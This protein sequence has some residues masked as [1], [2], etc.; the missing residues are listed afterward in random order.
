MVELVLN[1]PLGR[2]VAGRIAAPE[3]SLHAPHLLSVEVASA[4]R[5]LTEVGSVGQAS[6]AE[7]LQDAVN[8]D[9]A[10]YDHEVLLPRVWQLRKSLSAHDAVYVAL[11]E[12]LESPLLTADRR[13]GRT[14]GHSARIEVIA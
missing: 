2:L 14:K 4:L 11:A 3:E 8:L 9:I 12:V 7:A 10:R 5:R 1:T 13:L 6:A